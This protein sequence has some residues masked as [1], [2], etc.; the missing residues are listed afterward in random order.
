MH[1]RAM[2]SPRADA[3]SDANTEDK[4]VFR[5]RRLRIRGS[6]FRRNAGIWLRLRAM[7]ET[8]SEHGASPWE[9]SYGKKRLASQEAF[10]GVAAAMEAAAAASDLV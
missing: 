9:K 4:P 1:A 3:L 2:P 10:V 6:T 5:L 8:G 7:D